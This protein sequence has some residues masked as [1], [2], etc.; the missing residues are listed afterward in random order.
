MWYQLGLIGKMANLPD[1]LTLIR[2]H[3]S[4]GSI[5]SHKKQIGIGVQVAFDTKVTPTEYLEFTDEAVTKEIEE[6]FLD[7]IKSTNLHEGGD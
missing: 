4:C 7:W 3:E 2:W 5:K 1:V 6:I